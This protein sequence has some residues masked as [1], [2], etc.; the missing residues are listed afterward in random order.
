MPL[1]LR[2]RFSFVAPVALDMAIERLRAALAAPEA[3]C[4]GDVFRGHA[5]LHVPDAH[6]HIWSPFLSLDLEWH[7]DGTQV[8]GL[9][10]PKPSVWSLFVAAYAVC[11]FLAIVALT[12]GASQWSLGQAPWAFAGVPLAVLGGLVVY[13]LALYGQ[14]RGREQMDTLR[15]V[16][17]TALGRPALQ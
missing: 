17:D 14:R 2:P 15:R 12:F 13:G 10:G 6:Q 11:A 8:R 9:Y 5:V 1:R 16:L 7:P 3:G 4:R